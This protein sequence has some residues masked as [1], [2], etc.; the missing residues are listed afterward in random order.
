MIMTPRRGRYRSYGKKRATDKVMFNITDAMVTANSEITIF[1]AVVPCTWNGFIANLK[2]N[3][4]TDTAFDTNAMINLQRVYEGGTAVSYSFSQAVLGKEQNLLYQWQQQMQSIGA[5]EQ[6]TEDVFLVFKSKGRRL[7]K[8][9]DTIVLTHK[10][11]DT[12]T[13]ISLSGTVLGFILL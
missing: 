3:V 13:T 5:A 8:P 1:T 4:N 12:V 9:G 6:S 10:L 7:L 11:A 2:V